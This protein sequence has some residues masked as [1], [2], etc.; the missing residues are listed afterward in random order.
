MAHMSASHVE[1]RDK[2]LAYAASIN[3][4]VARGLSI[5][6]E[7]AGPQPPEPDLAHLV[8][9][10]LEA[11]RESNRH[12]TFDALRVLAASPFTSYYLA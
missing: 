12:R 3:A 8:P 11:L 5:G 7:A 9:N 4:F 1:W 6:W 2:V 10:L